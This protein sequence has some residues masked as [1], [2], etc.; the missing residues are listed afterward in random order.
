[1]PEYTQTYFDSVTKS[2]EVALNAATAWA[3][4]VQSAWDG[5]FN[6]ATSEPQVPN[7]VELVNVTFDN[8]EKLLDVQRDYY[9][10]IAQAYAPM[11]EKVAADAKRTATSVK[12]TA[13]A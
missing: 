7:P 3:D 2:Q 9:T 8:L 5:L 6:Q 10:G 1:M 11:V 13:K 12:T 4:Q